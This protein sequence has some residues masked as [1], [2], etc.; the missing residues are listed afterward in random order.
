MLEIAGQLGG[1]VADGY[2]HSY[3][4]GIESDRKADL[5]VV[6]CRVLLLGPPGVGKGTQAKELENLWGIPSI[7]TGSLLR[8]HVDQRTSLGC[9]AQEIMQR[10]ELVPDS[11]L[12]Q[13]VEDRLRGSDAAGGFILDGFPRTLGQAVWLEDL[14]ADLGQASSTIVIR[15]RMGYRQLL[16]RITGRR[17]C[18]VCETTYNILVNPP[19]RD[20]LCNKDGAALIQRTDDTEAIFGKRM[21]GYSKLTAPVV[22]YY[23]TLGRFADVDGNKPIGVITAGI[24]AAIDRLS[25]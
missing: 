21:R 6:P 4:T 1:V 15:I 14:L 9:A 17:N 24:T 8:A 11:M 23:R 5:R 22:D 20:G 25:Q 18:P 16:R 7:S 19:K 12:Y 10:G 2:R 13:I 3:A